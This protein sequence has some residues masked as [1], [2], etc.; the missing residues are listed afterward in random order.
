MNGCTNYCNEWLTFYLRTNRALVI[1]A[2][3][4]PVAKPMLLARPFRPWS[5]EEAQALLQEIVNWFANVQ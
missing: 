2:P 4:S 1:R 5:M 3:M